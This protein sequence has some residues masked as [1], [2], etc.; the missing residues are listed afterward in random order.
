MII[1]PKMLGQLAVCMDNIAPASDVAINWYQMDFRPKWERQ[2]QKMETR[3]FSEP[4]VS[5]FLKQD[6]KSIDHNGQKWKSYLKWV[7]ACRAV[8]TLVIASGYENWSVLETVRLSS[9]AKHQC[10][11]LWPR[12]ST[13]R[14]ILSRNGCSLLD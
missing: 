5:G 10:T 11:P 1:F 7:R 12:S 6:A 9:R 13:P 2:K 3:K 4:V 8:G 14:C